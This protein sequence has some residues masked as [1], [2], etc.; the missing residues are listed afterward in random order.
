MVDASAVVVSAAAAR[1][2]MAGRARML[3]FMLNQKIL[4]KSQLNDSEDC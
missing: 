3:N 1:A 4:N 2:R